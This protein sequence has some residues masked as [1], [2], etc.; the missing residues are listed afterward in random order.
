MRRAADSHMD[1]EFESLQ[2]AADRTGY[3]VYTF[4][5]KV[6]EGELKAYRLS[7]KPG[8][9][10][11]VRVADV[12]ALMRPLIPDE[13]YPERIHQIPARHARPVQEKD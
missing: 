10:I 12:D 1:P 7:D 11:R 2:R 4:R 5:D 13:V 8:S 3:S 6:A 9:A